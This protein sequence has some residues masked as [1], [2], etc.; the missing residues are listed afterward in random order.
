MPHEEALLHQ[1]FNRVAGG[2]ARHLVLSRQ[3]RF[4]GQAI[5]RE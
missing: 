3:L 1:G 5:T 4:C 2:H